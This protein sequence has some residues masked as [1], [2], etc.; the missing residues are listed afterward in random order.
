MVASATQRPIVRL[1]LELHPAPEGRLEGRLCTDVD[2][3]GTPFSG[4]LELLKAIEE[5]L[6]AVETAAH[7]PAK[8]GPSHDAQN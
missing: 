3:S 6:T 1:L 2:D 5:T 8:E 7:N 4:V